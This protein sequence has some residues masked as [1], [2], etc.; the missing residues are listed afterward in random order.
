MKTAK[1]IITALLLLSMLI[2]PLIS[3]SGNGVAVFRYR[4]TTLSDDVY[5]YWLSYYKTYYST[6]FSDITDSQEGWQK[7]VSEGLTAEEYVI[8][9]VNDRMKL[10]TVALELC[11]EYSIS[12]SSEEK[13]AVNTQ[14]D[15]L[16]DSFGGRS[17]LENYLSRS[18]NIGISTLKEVY[19]IERKIAKLNSYL[20]GEK[21]T[22]KLTQEQLDEFYNSHYSRIKYLYFDKQNKYV[23]DEDG[24]IVQGSSGKY[25]LEALTPEEKKELAKKVATAL[26]EAKS[27]EDFNT[28]IEKYN[29]PDMK[30]T[31]KYPN[32]FYISSTS[33]TSSEVY[34][35]VSNGM[36]LKAGDIEMVEDDQAYYI[37]AKYELEDKMYEKDEQNQFESFN[38]DAIEYYFSQF[39]YEKFDDIEINSD[40]LSRV[41]IGDV[42]NSISI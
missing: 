35:L 32:G 2:C 12:L 16:I 38:K 4:N 23:L 24:N 8:D 31:E 10:Y 41:S 3:C 14:I 29:T 15:S 18:A 19:T 17:I 27:G 33:Y 7:E 37:I 1:K 39:L 9:T 40:F 6:Y 34:T 26:S 30:Y 42:G 21:G 22:Q 20:Y 25:E 11:S 13:Q 28:L 5:R 36:K